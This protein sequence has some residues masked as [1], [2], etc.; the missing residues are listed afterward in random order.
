M[1]IVSFNGTL[2]NMLQMSYGIINLLE[3]L[4]SCTFLQ[5]GKECQ[6]CRIDNDAGCQSCY[7]GETKRHL[8]MRINEHLVTDKKSQISNIY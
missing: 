5:N 7:I 8:S 6:S 1:S 4:T 2:V 3:E